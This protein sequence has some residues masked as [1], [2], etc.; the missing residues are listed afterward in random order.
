VL[1]NQTH[2]IACLERAGKK[3]TAA[4]GCGNRQVAPY[5]E[6]KTPLRSRIQDDSRW[7]LHVSKWLSTGV[8]RLLA[9]AGWQGM[10]FM[11]VANAL[12]AITSDLQ[13]T[14]AAGPA[15]TVYLWHPFLAHAA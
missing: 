6:R 10:S 15:G 3:R 4:F 12:E 14:T 1:S 9:S 13:E 2:T 7:C 5:Q 11:E 8:A